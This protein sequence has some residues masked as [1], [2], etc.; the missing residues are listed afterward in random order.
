MKI[1]N[2]DCGYVIRA[3]TDDDLVDRAQAHIRTAHPNMAGK[4]T[5]EQILAMAEI[6]A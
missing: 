2:C 3:D 4:V 1:I 5:A 6:V